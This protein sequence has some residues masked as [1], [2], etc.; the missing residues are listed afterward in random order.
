MAKKFTDS[1]VWISGIGQKTSSAS[2]TKND[3]TNLYTTKS[4][5]DIAYNMAKITANEIDVA[6]IHDAFSICELMAVE[7]LGL[8][9]KTTGA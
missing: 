6:E 1:P 5:A 7:D 4:A 8:T 9:K 3:L 2:F